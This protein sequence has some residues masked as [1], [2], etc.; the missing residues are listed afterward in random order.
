VH[1]N[2][3]ACGYFYLY[4]IAHWNNK[5]RSGWRHKNLF[6]TLPRVPVINNNNKKGSTGLGSRHWVISRA[7]QSIF[8]R[9]MNEGHRSQFPCWKV[10]EEE[11]VAKLKE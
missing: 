1:I 8:V 9:R 2:R 6:Q 4:I 7:Y 11:N 5:D 3:C 10:K